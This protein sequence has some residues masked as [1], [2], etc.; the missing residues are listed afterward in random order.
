M[1]N[2]FR[3]GSLWATGW[4]MCGGLSILACGSRSSLLTALTALLLCL[5]L[6][7]LFT[8]PLPRGHVQEGGGRVLQNV[9]VT[10]SLGNNLVSFPHVHIGKLRPRKGRWLSRVYNIGA[11]TKP[12]SVPLPLGL[13]SAPSLVESTSVGFN[14]E[15]I[16]DQTEVVLLSSRWK[17]IFLKAGPVFYFFN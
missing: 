15:V 12:R 13:W 8:W 17:R 2:V 1:A 11:W 5:P 7:M 3:H 16:Q 4:I 14:N 9:S 6:L 10:K